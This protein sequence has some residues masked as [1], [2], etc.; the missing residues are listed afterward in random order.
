MVHIPVH[1]EHALGPRSLGRPRCH[2][3]VVEEA[4]A[5]GSV[6]AGMVACGAA[7]ESRGTAQWG[8]AVPEGGGRL[9]C[10]WAAG[11]HL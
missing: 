2:G 11:A 7:Q 1:D 8:A 10:S 6:M 3:C 5:L 4:A 9:H